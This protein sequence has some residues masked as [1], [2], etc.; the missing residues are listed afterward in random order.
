M[1]T[2]VPDGSSVSRMLLRGL[3]VWIVL[4]GAEFLHGIARAIWLVPVVGDSR[5]RQIGVFTGSIINPTISALLIRWMH[6]E[7][8]SDALTIGIMWFVLTLIFEI[9]FGRA[10]M[11]ASWQRIASDYDLPHGGVLPF[12]LVILALAPWI[13]AKVRR[14][15]V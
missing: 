12:G 5:S 7:S 4:I 15:L 3:V 1:M 13:T 14:L 10:V 11:N 8:A 9:G 6:P 2:T